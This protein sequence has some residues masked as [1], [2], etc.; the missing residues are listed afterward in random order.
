MTTNVTPPPG[1]ATAVGEDL[2]DLDFTTP[3]PWAAG[4]LFLEFEVGN[5]PLQISTAHWVDGVWFQNGAD[6]GYAVTVGNGVCTTRPEPTELRWLGAS[7]AP[8]ISGTLEVRGAP[9]TAG[10]S[11]GLVL[12][13]AGL[14][15]QAIGYG[16]SLTLLDP[17][18][19]GCHQWA[20]F[21]VTWSGTTGATG[22]CSTPLPLPSTAALGT[23]LGVQSA[24]LD[25]SRTGLPLSFSNG[26]YLQ[27]GAVGVGAR[28]STMFFP[29]AATA[30][31]WPAFV[32]QMPVLLLEH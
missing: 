21:E 32:G 11:A 9:P 13:W 8:G 28:C 19:V 5:A 7:P 18:L 17:T 22:V 31:P 3:L 12:G 6:S 23:K 20:P 10:S 4:S 29:G 24:W 15:P 26:L 16:V 14:D 1:P 2:I 27:L 25:L 30:S